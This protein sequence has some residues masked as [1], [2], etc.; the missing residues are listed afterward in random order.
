MATIVDVA[1]VAGVSVQT[2]SAVINGQPGASKA[3]RERIRHII[4][5]LDYQ[6]SSLARGLRSQ[7]TRTIG[8]LIPTLTNPYWTEMVRGAEDMAHRNGYAVFLGN[9]EGEPTRHSAYLQS[10]RRQRVVGIFFC[11]DVSC[12]EE[13]DQLTASGVHVVVNMAG[14]QP[15]GKAVSLAIE[16]EVA[17]CTATTHL[18]DLGHRRIGFIGPWNVAGIVVFGHNTGLPRRQGYERALRERGVE[19]DPDLAV[20]GQYDVADGQTGARRLMEAVSPPTA[21]VAA[22]DLIAIGVLRALKRLGKQVPEDVAVVGFDNIP[23]AKL[24][25][26]PLTTV[27][28]PLYE[29]G[30]CATQAILD[31]VQDPELPGGRFIF[32][33]TLIVRRST[34][35]GVDDDA[36]EPRPREAADKHTLGQGVSSTPYQWQEAPMR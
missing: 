4:K 1:R 22:N 30:T 32:P 2:V 16:D 11:D 20:M 17:G 25:D 29:M 10:L 19:P 14:W 8:I 27:A 24:Y 12:V 28:Q 5:E 7:S 15:R 33:T 3:T 34:V 31:R 9:T 18:L 36:D 26:P 6:P 23:I 21:I 35:A 13:V